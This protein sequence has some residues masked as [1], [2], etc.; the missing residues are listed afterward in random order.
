MASVRGLGPTIYS[1]QY[2]KRT[3]WYA[4]RTCSMDQNEIIN[5]KEAKK[6]HTQIQVLRLLLD[7]DTL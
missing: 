7:R 3:I 4:P 6:E 2:A 1:T 5:C